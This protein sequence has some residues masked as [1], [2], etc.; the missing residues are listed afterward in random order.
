MS[1]SHK[2][3]FNLSSNKRALLEALL[4]EGRLD[5]S[6]AVKLIKR[7]SQQVP[8]SYAQERLWFLDQFQPG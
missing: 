2:D 8:L 4:L 5:S 1:S 7:S 3:S 6:S